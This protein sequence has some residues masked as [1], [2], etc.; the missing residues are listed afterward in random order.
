M[1]EDKQNRMAER[2]KDEEEEGGEPSGQLTSSRMGN[3][4][5]TDSTRMCVSLLAEGSSLRYDSSMQVR[6][7]TQT[8]SLERMV[9]NLCK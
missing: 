4:S 5:T 6:S 3:V 9:G 7:C 1:E 2:L 8:W